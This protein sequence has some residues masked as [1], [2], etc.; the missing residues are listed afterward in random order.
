MDAETNKLD[1]ERSAA[2]E[3]R[4]GLA[5]AQGKPNVAQL[6]LEHLKSVQSKLGLQFTNVEYR[7]IFAQADNIPDKIRA[8]DKPNPDFDAPGHDLANDYWGERLTP[9]FFEKMTFG[10]Q[11]V[12]KTPAAVSLEWSVP[13][14]PDFH[15]FNMVLVVNLDSK[16]CCPT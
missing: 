2:R 16:T 8:M 9:A 12:R 10:S 5:Q 11:K 3:I 14:P 7:G 1:S 13:S 6:V 4:F 15:H